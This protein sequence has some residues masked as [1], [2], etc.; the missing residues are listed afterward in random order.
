MEQQAAAW[1]TE[2]EDVSQLANDWGGCLFW[3]LHHV[4][5]SLKDCMEY[6]MPEWLRRAHECEMVIYIYENALRFKPTPPPRPLS[7]W[8]RR[9]QEGN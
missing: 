1:V 3:K 4:E 2:C 9:A 8:E 6:W 7:D 5:L